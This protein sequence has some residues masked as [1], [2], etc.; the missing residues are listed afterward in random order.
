MEVS[1]LTWSDIDL[2]DGIICF[3]KT[4][5][6]QERK[7]KIS[8]ELVYLLKMKKKTQ[9]YV[10]HN[11][12][13]DQFTKNKLRRAI[14]EFKIRELYKGE[15]NPLDLRHSFAVNFLSKGGEIKKLQYLMGH[16]NVFDTKMLYGEAVTRKLS[17][18]SHDVLDKE[19]NVSSLYN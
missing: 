6:S 1:D 10:F 3:P 17:T 12:Y 15:W 4:I 8:D 5:A 7:M 9:G 18:I 11:H 14:D 13:G 19:I 16:S 2:A